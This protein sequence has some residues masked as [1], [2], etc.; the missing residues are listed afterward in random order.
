MNATNILKLTKE[1]Q[2]K[3]KI[4]YAYLAKV[5]I[6]AWELAVRSKLDEETREEITRAE[7]SSKKHSEIDEGLTPSNIES[8]QTYKHIAVLLKTANNLLRNHSFE[9]VNAMSIDE[10]E[11][12]ISFEDRLYLS[13]NRVSKMTEGEAAF[14]NSR[15]SIIKYQE[16]GALIQELEQ[17]EE[18]E[19]SASADDEDSDH[20]YSSAD[21]ES[22]DDLDYSDKEH[23]PMIQRVSAHRNLE[24][25]GREASSDSS[26]HE[27]SSSD[28]ENDSTPKKTEPT[29]SSKLAFKASKLTSTPSWLPFK[30][31]RQTTS[32]LFGST[33][34]R[35]I[36]GTLPGIAEADEPTLPTSTNTTNTTKYFYNK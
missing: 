16:L 30:A 9:I 33:Q 34:N 35:V 32:S 13:T 23:A 22:D 29:P 10:I 6:L 3:Y 28:A 27:S 19:N 4:A 12:R 24:K 26:S 21:S 7:R 2:L 8:S 15:S 36:A 18:G 25:L 5:A 14:E 31:P 20:S 17:V 1:D 11:K